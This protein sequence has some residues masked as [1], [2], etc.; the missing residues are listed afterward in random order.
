MFLS[1]L[2][3]AALALVPAVRGH[4]AIWDES[5]YGFNNGDTNVSP[6]SGRGFNDWW[7]HGEQQINDKPS[8]VKTLVP[9]SSVNFEIS[10]S[11]WHTSF[12]G[13]NGND[14]CPN[15]AGAYHAGGQ[16]GSQS[17]WNGNNEENLL[18]CALAIAYKSNPRDVK[19]EDFIVFSVQ[20]RCV[21]QKDTS[22]DIPANLPSCPN[23]ECTCA[24]FWQGKNSANEMYMNGFR[25]NVQGGTNGPIPQPVAP[26]RNQI[27]GPTQPMYW[28][29]DVNNVGYQPE[30]ANK[31][32]YNS[33]WGWTNGAQTGA[34]GAGGG[35]G[36][37]NNPVN[38]TTGPTGN[39]EPVTS[40]TSTR[41]RRPRPTEWDANGSP[42][43]P[44]Y[45][46][47]QPTGTETPPNGGCT[48]SRKRSH[49]R[50]NGHRR[51]HS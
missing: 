20:E 33:A 4:M 6:L 46:A 43:W 37:N 48:R 19:P 30:W 23:G 18:G 34:F 44:V 45:A 31:P 41:R 7:F 17:G 26:R 40:T 1:L 10:C 28:A 39:W 13:N 21:R 42:K 29:N 50:R 11:K 8:S 25:C 49:K 47:P 15:D 36:G 16:T 12:T 2:F 14:A 35:S 3:S 9:G 24:W 27:S 51:V 5:V 22:F 38:T 32:S